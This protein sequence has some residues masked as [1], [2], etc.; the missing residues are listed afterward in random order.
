MLTNVIRVLPL[1]PD[2]KVVV[3]V[4]NVKEPRQE[5]LALL[6]CHAVDVTDMAAD[7]EDALPP[8]HRVGTDDGM[9]GLELCP[10]VFRGATRL[11]VELEPG[12]L[13]D[14]TEGRL[15][16]SGCQSLKESLIRLRDAVVDII[17]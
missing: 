7:R 4:D 9:N 14:I 6:L 11:V 5:R 2:L 1:E 16:E 12:T 10:D 13:G 3:F 8:C 15:L 17:A